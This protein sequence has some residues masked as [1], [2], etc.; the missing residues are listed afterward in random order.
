MWYSLAFMVGWFGCM[1][2]SW[3]LN[4]LMVEP[5]VDND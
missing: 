4:T 3:L 1:G 2:F 5:T